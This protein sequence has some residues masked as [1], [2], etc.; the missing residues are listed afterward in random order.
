MLSQQACSPLV[1]MASKH[2]DAGSAVQRTI[3]ANINSVLFLPQIMVRAL[4]S[5]L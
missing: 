3:N 1:G 4:E 2:A 5:L